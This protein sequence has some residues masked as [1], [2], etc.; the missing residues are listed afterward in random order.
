MDT[1]YP[2]SPG[3]LKVHRQLKLSI[4][5][6][7]GCA[8]VS[9]VGFMVLGWVKGEP[10]TVLEALHITAN[11]FTTVGDIDGQFTVAEKV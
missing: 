1:R 10:R 3:S 2:S 6:L 7:L 4:V 9:I 11:I 8:V 5:I